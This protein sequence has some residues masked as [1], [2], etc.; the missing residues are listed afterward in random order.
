M[1]NNERPLKIEDKENVYHGKIFL[2][3]GAASGIG[4]GIAEAAIQRNAEVIG[5][6]KNVVQVSG[7]SSTH[8]IDITNKEGLEKTTGDIE[9]NNNKK[10]DFLILS[11]GIIQSKPGVI[12]EE[13]RESM[14]NVN[15]QGTINSFEAFKPLLKDG[16]TVVFLS[17]DLINDPNTS[18]PDYA[19]SK[20]KIAEFAQRQA[21]AFGNI[22]I[23]T[24]LPGPV[25]TP[26]FRHG[27]SEETLRRIDA[28]VGIM[29]P[30]EFATE[31]LHNILP[32]PTDYP[33]G[34]KIRMYK[35]K[36]EIVS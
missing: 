20:R 22:R 11:A 14:R 26:L 21:V 10:T 31:L 36:T 18:V 15:I 33:S 13:E 19:E 16:A 4:K 27:K 30:E 12:S 3:T 23:I 7:L 8:E 2:I 24:L 35:G 9:R 29:T 28:A 17:S 32:N 34:S 25:D 5:L 1:D 6:D